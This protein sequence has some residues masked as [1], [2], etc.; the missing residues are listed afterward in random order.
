M[1]RIVSLLLVI[2]LVTLSFGPVFAADTANGTTIRLTELSGTVTV[3]NAAGKAVTARADM[4]LYNGYTVQTGASSSAYISLDNSKAV[5]L[6]AA[7]K[8]EVKKSGKQLEISLSAGKVFFNVDKPLTN[9]ESLNI[10]TVTM[11]TGVRGSFGWVGQTEVGLIHGHVQLTCTN[12]VT[13][14]TRYTELSSGQGV[15][16]KGDDVEPTGGEEGNIEEIS[17]EKTTL[18]ADMVPAVAAEEIKANESY[19]EQIKADV[20]TLDVEEIIETADEKAEEEA[21]V[22]EEA[23]A[24]AEEEAAALDEEIVAQTTTVDQVYEESEPEPVFIDPSTLPSSNSHTVSFMVNGSL[25]YSE[26]VADGMPIDTSFMETMGSPKKDD[27]LFVCWTTDADGRNEYVFAAYDSYSDSYIETPVT[28]DLTLYAK[29]EP[30]PNAGSGES[31]SGDSGDTP[32]DPGNLR[33]P[34]FSEDGKAYAV[35]KS[36]EGWTLSG[37]YT[38]DDQG[39]HLDTVDLTIANGYALYSGL[40]YFVDANQPNEISLEQSANEVDQATGA[41]TL[42]FS[43]S[44]Y[45]ST[46]TSSATVLCSVNVMTYGGD[47]SNYSEYPFS[48]TPTVVLFDVY[49]DSVIPSGATVPSGWGVMLRPVSDADY[50]NATY[51]DFTVNGTLIVDK[52]VYVLCELQNSSLTVGSDGEIILDG[53]FSLSGGTF[54]NNGSFI[55]ESDSNGSSEG[56]YIGCMLTNNGTIEIAENSVMMLEGNGQLINSSGAT[57]TGDGTLQ[58]NEYFTNNGTVAETVTVLDQKGETVKP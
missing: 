21:A 35:D 10:R 18:T 8:I 20:P 47:V 53:C 52:H 34:Y 32:I 4:R 56:A 58:I 36:T 37:A 44:E 31:G 3:K 12:P 26:T 7:S 23:A 14:E 6:D 27:Y 57:I 50:W 30:D 22:I 45:A 42:R 38:A 25:W 5:K 1:K 9:D 49:A 43:A 40:F 33:I 2:L 46:A 24:K 41:L 28:S 16:Y 15:S 13:G 39:Y 17:F 19:Q 55:V 51:S 48:G 54:V 29:F 11:V